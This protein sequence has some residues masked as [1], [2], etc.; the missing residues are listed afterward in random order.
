MLDE[1]PPSFVIGDVV[2]AFGGMCRG[3][4]G[5]FVGMGSTPSRGQV[6]FEMMSRAV[7]LEVSL[8]DLA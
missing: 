5:S 4:I 3:H 6:V 7:K 8:Y 1:E 2:V